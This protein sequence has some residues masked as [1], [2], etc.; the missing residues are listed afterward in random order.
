MLT[1]RRELQIEWG[2]CDPA[3][4]VFYP[5]YFAMFDASTDRLLSTGFGMV[6][7]KWTAKYGILG[8]PMVK[9]GG[10]FFAPCKFGDEVAIDSEIAD[11]SR[12]SFQV[13]HVLSR[14]GTKSVEASETRV[15]TARDPDDPGRIRA[16]P[17]PEEVVAIL[18]GQAG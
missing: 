15:W 9:T 5:R 12:S 1:N 7:I 6:K 18:R 14:N 11:L 4:I 3:G 8:I 17:M 10:E 16:V 2:D 13:R